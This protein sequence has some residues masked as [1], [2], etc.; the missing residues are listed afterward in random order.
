MLN[1]LKTEIKPI[2][3]KNN[4][5]RLSV[6]GS[7]ARGEQNKNSDIDILVKFNKEKS[8]LDL[9]GLKYEL[10]EKLQREV[11]V[12]TYDSINPLLRDIIQKDEILVYGKR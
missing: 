12:L 6:F 9:I 4:V 5:S 10:Q 2:L 7:F 8:L 3:I 11:D 1:K